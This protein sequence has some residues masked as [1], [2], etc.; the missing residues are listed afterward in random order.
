MEE[1]GEVGASGAAHNPT[2]RLAIAR[3]GVVG[4]RGG[5]PCVGGAARCG[6]VGKEKPSPLALAGFITAGPVGRPAR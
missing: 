1:E 5:V 4:L 3:G 2:S 6:R